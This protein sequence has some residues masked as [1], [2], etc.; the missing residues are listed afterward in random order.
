MEHVGCR[1]H[2]ISV[3]V[4]KILQPAP[5]IEAWVTSDGRAYFVRLQESRHSETIG[6]GERNYMVGLEVFVY[7]PPEE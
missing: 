4:I 1:I 5:E 7:S 3:T 6:E 2:Y